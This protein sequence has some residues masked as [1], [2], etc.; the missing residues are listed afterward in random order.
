MGD[1]ERGC[2]GRDEKRGG[3]VRVFCEDEKVYIHVLHLQNAKRL[4]YRLRK[5]HVNS[6]TQIHQDLNRGVFTS[7]CTLI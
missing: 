6:L 4:N 1:E 7:I 3:R 5:V 2:Q